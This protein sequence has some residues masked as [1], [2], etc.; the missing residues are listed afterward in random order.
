MKTQEFL[1]NILNKKND[2]DKLNIKLSET[3]VVFRDPDYKIFKDADVNIV[4]RGNKYIL[5]ID[6]K[7]G[8]VQNDSLF[9]I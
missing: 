7:H 2:E 5:L 9:G 3:Q 8:K 4:Y 6:L 1:N